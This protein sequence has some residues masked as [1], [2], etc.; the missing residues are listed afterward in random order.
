LA[1]A[2]AGLW[3]AR[4][5]IGLGLL[6]EA[7][8]H[9]RAAQS[10]AS[11]PAY[12]AFVPLCQ[13]AVALLDEARGD[14]DEAR[15]HIGAALE[16]M[17]G[18]PCVRIDAWALAAAESLPPMPAASSALA[19]YAE[20]R[21]A[22]RALAAGDAAAA[23]RAAARA[24]AWYRTHG[25]D[26]EHARAQV[27]RGEAAACLGRADDAQ[28][29]LA[30]GDALAGERG[31]RLFEVRSAL[32]HA[33]L[34]DRAGDLDG[35]ARAIVRA[36]AL[37]RDGAPNGAV[38]RAAARLG[39]S[40]WRRGPDEEPL[41][42]WRDCARRLGLL[43]ARDVLCA[44]P[45]RLELLADDE[46]V[47]AELC[48][49]PERNELEGGGK[50]VTLFPQLVRLFELFVDAGVQ[51]VSAEEIYLCLWSSR[52]YHRLRHRNNVYVAVARLRSLS[53]P[54]LDGA[55][56]IERVDDRYRLVPARSVAVVRRIDDAA[57][58]GARLRRI[59]EGAPAASD[60]A[61]YA[62]ELGLPLPIARWE[63]ALRGA[64]P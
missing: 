19:G 17:P 33:A 15:A 46:P 54:L 49:H 21:R 61:S 4:A 13:R 57:L 5:A 11:Q 3:R 23:E 62:R 18:S 29:A 28:A 37:A 24:V 58:E 47:S 9:V 45:G 41:D 8:R 48:A 16:A 20:L 25:M 26:F 60:V 43:R 63:C 22:E 35:Y 12:A 27:L 1:T 53:E 14:A 51:G 36:R 7:E 30:A 44:R 64:M 59:G 55:P 38:A 50:R 6:D 42:P 10:V 39:L 2:F 56:L 40:P 31:Y 52:E 32:V 34:A